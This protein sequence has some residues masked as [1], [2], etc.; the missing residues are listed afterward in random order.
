MEQ[1]RGS[2]ALVAREGPDPGGRPGG[3]PC[4]ASEGTRL[5]AG[6]PSSR[7]PQFSSSQRVTAR[8]FGKSVAHS[9]CLQPRLLAAPSLPSSGFVSADPLPIPAA[10]GPSGRDS[11]A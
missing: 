3:K 2:N 10:S 6:P 11:G 4:V 1:F 9:A 8:S 7:E 5:A